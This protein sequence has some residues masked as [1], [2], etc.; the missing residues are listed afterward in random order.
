MRTITLDD[1]PPGT[2]LDQAIAAK[3]DE[4][5][6]SRIQALIREGNLKAGGKSITDSSA[7]TKEGVLYELTIPATKASTL[8]AENISLDIVFEDEHLLVINKPAGMTVH[9]SAGH[10]EGTLVHALLHHCGASLSGIGGVGRPGIVHRLDKDTSGLM[11]VAKNDAAHHHLSEQLATRTLKRVYNAIVW[12]R[13]KTRHG[14]I[15][16]NISRS[17]ANR[18]KMAIT[19]TGKSA[20]T[21]FE[22]L[23]VFWT[24]SIGK[25]PSEAL[26]SLV[27]CRLETGRTH[28]IRVHLSAQG[29]GL[30]GDPLYGNTT[31]HRL[32]HY[33]E[34][35]IKPNVYKRLQEFNRQALHALEIGFIHPISGKTMHFASTL[36]DDIFSL[37]QLL[38]T[39]GK[40]NT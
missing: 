29:N 19:K 34:K 37:L 26:V 23:E 35:A 10:S 31:P 9:P 17:T 24:E 13:M 14:E 28:Q 1:L 8:V 6:R 27:E 18:K 16:G 7:K 22:E 11:V 32:K 36:P 5:S 30:L 38:K 4:F 20:R 25:R 2:R 40:S 39:E 15:E 3:L 33:G 21:H 12:G